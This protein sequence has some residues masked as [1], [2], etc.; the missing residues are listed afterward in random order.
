MCIYIIYIILHMHLSIS[1]HRFFF[2]LYQHEKYH[3]HRRPE[4]SAMLFS[5][6][7]IYEFFGN[8][9]RELARLYSISFNCLKNLHA[10]FHNGY[11]NLHSHQSLTL[12]STYCDHCLANSC[13][14]K[15][16]VVNPWDFDLHFT[17]WF[18]GFVT[19]S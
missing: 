16:G 3:K 17:C 2:Y 6:L 14:S 5:S 13:S 7:G 19:Y 15:H 12:T 11:T 8:I 4:I 10:I 18:V 1:G 9:C